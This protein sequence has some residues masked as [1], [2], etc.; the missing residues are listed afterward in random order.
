MLQ[1]CQQQT[2]N[3]DET[4]GC[5]NNFT[6]INNM[7]VALHFQKVLKVNNIYF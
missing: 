5:N 4:T 2:L 3:Q 7:S 6:D 1:T